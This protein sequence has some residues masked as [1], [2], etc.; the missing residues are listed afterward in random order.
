M[1]VW[2][3]VCMITGIRIGGITTNVFFSKVLAPILFHKVL[4]E[5]V[6]ECRFKCIEIKRNRGFSIKSL[7]GNFYLI[8]HV[9]ILEGKF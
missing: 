3:C 6:G 5:G 7:I 1:R 2:V 4:L 8:D 9:L